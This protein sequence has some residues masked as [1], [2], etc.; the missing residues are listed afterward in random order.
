M[1]SLIIKE[2]NFFEDYTI[3]WDK[4][5]GTGISGKVF[6]CVDN[7]DYKYAVKIQPDCEEARREAQIQWDCRGCDHVVELVD[8]YANL[9]EEEDKPY[10]YIIMGY[11]NNGEFYGYL[12]ENHV[13]EEEARKLVKQIIQAIDHLHSLNIAHRDLKPENIL[14]HVM[15]GRKILKLT[16]FGYAE[17]DSRKFTEPLYTLYYAAPEVLL[18]DSRFNKKIEEG[19]TLYDKRCDLW[20]LGVITYILLMRYPPFSPKGKGGEMTNEMYQ[21]IVTGSPYYVESDW[22]KYSDEAHDFVFGLLQ[23]NPGDRQSAKELLQHPWIR[24]KNSFENLYW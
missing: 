24:P 5:L 16:D 10:L 12:K 17:I 19:V 23:S 20:S 11:V 9:V 7:Y 13:S 22:D 4:P 15:Y 14:V 18:N 3:H 6:E 21:S 1:E 8:V 2:N